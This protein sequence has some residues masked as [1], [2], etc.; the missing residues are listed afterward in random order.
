MR[1][2]AAIIRNYR[3]HRDLTVEFDPHRTLIAGDNESGKS[4][5]VEA[6]HRALF[7]KST[8][9]GAVLDE[10][11]SR[12]YTGYPEV[13]LRFAMGEGVYELR[14]RFAGQQG[15]VTL[16]RIGGE[17][18]QGE[19]AEA[20][21]AALLGVEPAGGGRGI[22]RRLLSQ[23]AHLWVWQGH[24]GEDPAQY[25]AAQQHQL[26]QRLQ[27][28]GGAVAM[29][30]ARDGRIA[31][32]FAGLYEDIFIKGGKPK[33]SSEL[34][35][36]EAE[37]EKARER[38]RQAEA[39]VVRLDQAMRESENAE[40]K[41]RQAKVSLDE[42]QRELQA[43]NEKLEKLNNLR[44]QEQTQCRELEAI[45]DQLAALEETVRKIQ[46]H[47]EQA[48]HIQG[49]LS[50]LQNELAII[51]QR[52]DDMQQRVE[53][54]QKEQDAAREQALRARTI[55]DMFA[56]HEHVL[57]ARQR[58]QSLENQLAAIERYEH[59]IRQRHE[60]LARL[61]DVGRKELNE[62]V[63]LDRKRE[64]AE[65]S[66]KAASPEI[67]LLESSS[68]VH[69]G[70][71]LLPQGRR[72]AVTKAV[73]LKAR[74]LRVCIR[75][76][77]GDSL[78]SL[79]ARVAAFDREIRQTLRG[80]RLTSI[81]K[82]TALIVERE[83]VQQEIDRL[84][85]ALDALDPVSTRAEFNAARS[86]LVATQTKLNR[87]NQT[88]GEERVLPAKF[89]TA[90]QEVRNAQRQVARAE[91]AE[92]KAASD[93]E[94][95]ANQ[96][97]QL[98]RERG[99]KEQSIRDLQRQLN[100]HQV[101]IRILV[102]QAG[103][104]T[105][106]RNQ[107]QKAKDSVQTLT[108]NLEKIRT[109]IT[110]LQPDLLEADRER[111]KRIIQYAQDTIRS[112]EQQ[113]AAAR[114][115]LQTDGTD[116]PHA[117][118][119]QARARLAVAEQQLQTVRRY[120]DAIALVHTLFEAQQRELTERF[121]RPLAEKITT[122]LQPVLGV[123]ARAVARFEGNNFIGV[124]LV[125]PDIPGTLSFDALSGGTR[126][127]IAAAVRLAIAE[128]LAADHDATLPVVFDDA[129]VNSDPNRIVLLQRTLDLGAR[130]GLQIIVLTCHSASYTALGARQ[131][132]LDP[133]RAKIDADLAPGS[134]LQE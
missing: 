2:Q 73:E 120:A 79:R 70:K 109:A 47:R 91:S 125:R 21:L 104:E 101:T 15:T 38:V 134:Q 12:L 9:T 62:L 16:S 99:K 126:E 133:P 49:T 18:W 6:I 66:L 111:L 56:A 27:R 3:L 37:T 19:E 8:V 122:Y 113:R 25:V 39:R 52:L 76:G 77:G 128:L 117:E 60:R 131:V 100:E 28:I 55:Q 10:M 118:L 33:A 78:A 119:A 88:L 5:L 58:Q 51:D 59:Q 115:L 48:R 4:T 94:A 1:L 22:E 97:E 57:E 40:T 65:A 80:W 127:Q 90:R 14:K 42:A 95:L 68:P 107:I 110:K 32:H 53:Q 69:L 64:R 20:R 82:A 83:T 132:I 43:V 11:H 26:L 116:D 45:Q 50:P 23:W 129:F 124:A 96:R 87:L 123:H 130:R 81:K 46:E 74:N 41:L 54:A 30:S 89:D 121:S 106:R 24:G 71:R 85:A 102:E 44:E 84:Q 31:E 13:E 112:A 86:N 92:R 108:D 98:F 35:A 114:A 34:A 61:P 93:R 36:A 105:Q 67:E 29:Q 63:S 75:P 7:L 72:I 17:S 103:D